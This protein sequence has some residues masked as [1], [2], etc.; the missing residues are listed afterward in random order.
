M[1]RLPYCLG[2]SNKW[3]KCRDSVISLCVRL[4]VTVKYCYGI[5]VICLLLSMNVETSLSYGIEWSNLDIYLMSC[6][7]EVVVLMHCTF[8]LSKVTPKFYFSWCNFRVGVGWIWVAPSTMQTPICTQLVFTRK[9]KANGD[10]AWEF[11]WMS[12]TPSHAV[13]RVHLALWQD[14]VEITCAAHGISVSMNKL[15]CFCSQSGTT[16]ATLLFKMSFS[17]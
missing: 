8:R 13:S 9:R 12:R 5:V 11:A 10:V 6:F 4:L 16:A 1:P 14:E 15:Q 7:D 3:R 2:W 17:T